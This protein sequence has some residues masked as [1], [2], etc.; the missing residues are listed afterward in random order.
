[1]LIR[2]LFFVSQLIWVVTF[3]A[4]LPI[5]ILLVLNLFIL[6]IQGFQLKYIWHSFKL[7]LWFFIP[8]ILLHGLFTPGIMVQYPIYLPVSVEGLMRGL[9]LSLHIASIFFTALVLFRIFSRQELLYFMQTSSLFT[10]MTPY[11]QLL[12]TLKK[13]VQHILIAQKMKW[14]QNKQK[15]RKLPDMLVESIQLVIS[16]SKNVAADLWQHWDEYLSQAIEQPESI[17]IKQSLYYASFLCMGWLV[18]WL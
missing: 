15:W 1:M 16:T 8:T 12:F 10:T 9:Y 2:W 17:V 11:T 4:L 18:F 6:I 13:E 5:F 3:D 7:L 14:Q